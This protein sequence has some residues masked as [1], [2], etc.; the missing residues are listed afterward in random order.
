M[1][2][3]QIVDK[4]EA[5]LARRSEKLEADLAALEAEGAKADVKRKVRDG[6]ERE[7]HRTSSVPPTRRSTTWSGCSTGSAPSRSRTSK[8]TRRSTARCVTATACTSRAAWARRP[9]RRLATFDLEAEA[10]T[11]REIVRTGKGQRKTRRS[12]GCGS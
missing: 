3:Q 12:S 10:E 6:A 7:L 5:D 9:S 8:A 2:R 1:E 4:V 11:L